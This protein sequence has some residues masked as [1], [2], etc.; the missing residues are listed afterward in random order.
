[1]F[2]FC[3]FSVSCEN[4]GKHK[5][6]AA[7]VHRPD[8]LAIVVFFCSHEIDRGYG[9]RREIKKEKKK[10]KKKFIFVLFWF[11]FLKAGDILGG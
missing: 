8:C 7:T 11:V 6:F 2:Q 9:I 10:K 5:T 3:K 1:M 4:S